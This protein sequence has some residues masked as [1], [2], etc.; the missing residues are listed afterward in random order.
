MA[1]N[2][3]YEIYEESLEV[4]LKRLKDENAGTNDAVALA[5]A[6]AEL[7]NVGR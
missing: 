7:L 6:I 4:L 2:R 5:T 1:S 3:D